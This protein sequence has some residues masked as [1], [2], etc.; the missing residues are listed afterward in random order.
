MQ[1]LCLRVEYS[2]LTRPGSTG[3][4]VSTVETD[5]EFR[6]FSMPITHSLTHSMGHISLIRRSRCLMI[7]TYGSQKSLTQCNVLSKRAFSKEKV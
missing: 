5:D 1:F 2:E 3:F 6:L 7:L 4:G